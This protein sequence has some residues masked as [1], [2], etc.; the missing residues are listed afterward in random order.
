MKEY[1]RCP[2]CREVHS[3]AEWN[4]TTAKHMGQECCIAP[5][6]QHFKDDETLFYCPSCGKKCYGDELS[7]Y[8]GGRKDLPTE[9]RVKTLHV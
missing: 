8:R 2:S 1:Y 9:T 4:Y 7:I 6:P 3:D 5:L